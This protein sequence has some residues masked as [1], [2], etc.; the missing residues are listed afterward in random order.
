[1]AGLGILYQFSAPN[2]PTWMRKAIPKRA[3]NPALLQALNVS[4][5]S[6]VGHVMRR[7]ELNF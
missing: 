2:T 7:G 6:K 3:K 1:M 5:D 4:V